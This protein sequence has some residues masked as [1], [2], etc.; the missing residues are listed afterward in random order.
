MLRL[1]E[2]QMQKRGSMI[3]K[4]IAQIY[5]VLSRFV[6][7]L[8]GVLILQTATSHQAPWG[9]QLMEN[10]HSKLLDKKTTIH[11]QL[12]LVDWEIWLSLTSLIWGIG[13]ILICLIYS[14]SNSRKS[15]IEFVQGRQLFLVVMI[16]FF[17]LFLTKIMWA[18][19]ILIV[20]WIIFL[21]FHLRTKTSSFLQD[22][23]LF[24]IRLSVVSVFLF[25]LKPTP[26]SWSIVLYL[27]FG[28]L[29]ILF[30]LIGTYPVLR[31]LMN[32]DNKAS[33]VFINSIEKMY[34]IFYTVNPVFFLFFFFFLTFGLTNLGSYFLFE[35]IPHVTDSIKQ[36]F[37]G[38][39]FSTGR[40]TAQA[41]LHREFFDF[42]AM[43]NNMRGD[44][45]WYSEYPPGHVFLMMWG[46]I[47]DA[48]WL[49][50]PLLGTLT[51]LLLYFL[52]KE[53]Y[54]EKTGRLATLL[55]VLSPFLMIMSSEFMNHV[56]ALFFLTFFLLFFIKTVCREKKWYHP[57]LAGLGLGMVL[58]IRPYTAVAT[59][60][61]FGIYSL[62]LLKKDFRAYLFRMTTFILVVLCFIGILLSYNYIT[63]GSPTLFGYVIQFG[64][65]HNI[66]FGHSALD[67]PYH[68]PQRGLIQNLQD[69]NA[70][71]KHLFEWPI[72]SLLFVLIL[73][74]TG[75][76]N[77]WDCLLIISV[78][79]L[80]FAY[81]FYWYQ[82]WVLGPRFM[83]E[84][85]A[86]LILL[87]ARGIRHIPDFIRNVLKIRTTER[88]VN[89]II[90]LSFLLSLSIGL[91]CHMPPLVTYYSEKFYK[92]STADILKSVE[93]AQI[94]NAIVFVRSK[95]FGGVLPANDPLLESSIIYARDL[96]E[97]NRLLMEYY[98]DREYYRAD[99]ITLWKLP[100]D[101]Q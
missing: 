18:F 21:L 9:S 22:M 80:S 69:L 49:I 101:T 68:T 53:L 79:S 2:N 28:S 50:N 93:R 84:S 57:I 3:F 15:L 43:M 31:F 66:G 85:S 33:S 74:L 44:G 87:T 67:K 59:V 78:I 40:L 52:G 86:M 13:L 34:R 1:N 41:H 54:D 47:F 72:P 97:R 12:T 89:S 29:G 92:N 4:P 63:N 17:L 32:R 76:R 58:N 38:K 70:L 75:P 16:V 88:M 81:F 94:D 20:A 45:K 91:F 10:V 62:L 39:I 8:L 7:F 25:T 65:G 95:S 14:S 98:P 61:P 96:G 100:L 99:G 19:F 71:N 82:G 6:C 37:H 35:H 56:S 26:R 5:Y 83:Y 90:A 36:V 64:T 60:M 23:Q 11:I 51:V 77:K 48:P 24:L 42:R 73:F 27:I 46:C 30:I 55:G